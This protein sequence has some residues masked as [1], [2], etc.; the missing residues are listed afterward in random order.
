MVEFKSCMGKFVINSVPWWN[1]S[2]NGSNRLVN[3]QRARP[4]GLAMSKNISS[5]ANHNPMCPL[6]NWFW[7]VHNHKFFVWDIR[8]KIVR[9]KYLKKLIFQ[10]F[11]VLN[12]IL[13]HD[14]IQ[15]QTVEIR[16]KFFVTLRSDVTNTFDERIP[17][18][19]TSTFAV[20]AFKN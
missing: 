9:C 8:W 5:V 1:F 4:R 2:F 10:M 12:E 16:K 13:Q 15:F 20:K 14:F 6:K 19:K 7:N 18:T 3:C 17:H 11:T